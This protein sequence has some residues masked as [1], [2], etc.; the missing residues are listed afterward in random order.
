MKSL[1]DTYALSNGVNIPVIGLGTWQAEGE[2]VKNA[3][4]AALDAGYRHI[5]T[6]QAYHNEEEVGEA[7]RQSGLKRGEVFLTSKL[8]NQVRGYEE[9]LAAFQES[10]DR[11]ET[12]YLDLFLLHWP[13]PIKYKDDWAAQNAASWRAMEDLVAEKRIRAIGI[14]NF[15]AHHIDELQKT[16]RLMPVVNQIRQCPGDTQE[17]VVAASRARGMLLEAYS[18]LGVGEVFSLPEMRQLADKYGRTIAQ[19]ALR[20]SLQQGFLPLPKSV[21]KERIKENAQ[22]FDF[23]LEEQDIALISGLTGRAG[24]SADPDNISW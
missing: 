1:Q 10:L 21:T 22:V 2:E 19:V 14:S 11:L 17:A 6:A 23:E 9:T 3:V 15:H 13:R 7:V 24:L 5:D 16:A 20:W 12:D 4:L 8:S 18:P